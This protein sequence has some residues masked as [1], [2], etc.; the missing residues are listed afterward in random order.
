MLFKLNNFNLLI[1]EIIWLRCKYL[2]VI[3]KDNFKG[4]R[5]KNKKS[6]LKNK[7]DKFFS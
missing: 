6:I 5:I 2:Y 7:I 1:N 3:L 4:L